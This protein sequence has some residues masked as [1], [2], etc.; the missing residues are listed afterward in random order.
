MRIGVAVSTFQR[1]DVLKQAVAAWEEYLPSDAVFRVIEDKQGIGVAHTKNRGLAALDGCDHVFLVDDDCWP[2]HPDWYLPY[3]N[4][5]EP[6]LMY[7]WGKHRLVA[8]HGDLM[9]YSHP[10][11]VSLY[12]ERRVIDRVGGYREEFGRWGSEH[13]EYSRRIHNCGF[14][15][16]AFQDVHGSGEYWH[17]LDR[18]IRGPGYATKKEQLST[19]TTA[20]RKKSYPHRKAL[21]DEYQDS[22]DYVAYGRQGE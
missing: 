13:V 18:E 21:M 7:C 19:V 22:T 9:E 2:K 17:A 1:P 10:R 14:T 3:V 12:L 4:H 5:T 15:K 20:E 6:H 11:G 16:F 8:R